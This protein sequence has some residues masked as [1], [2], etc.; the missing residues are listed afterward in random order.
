MYITTTKAAMTPHRMVSGSVTE[1]SVMSM[2]AREALP[3]SVAV[4]LASSTY[5]CTMNMSSVMHRSTTAIAA[6][7]SLS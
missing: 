7:P 4:L 2:R 5:F 1:R 6:A 3:V